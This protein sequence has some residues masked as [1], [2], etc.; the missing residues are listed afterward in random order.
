MPASFDGFS[1][2][3]SSLVPIR[4]AFYAIPTDLRLITRGQDTVIDALELARERFPEAGQFQVY[5]ESFYGS[6]QTDMQFW[7]SYPRK[8]VSYPDE[9]S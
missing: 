2:N 5:A 9:S 4:R 3:R 1:E 6:E 7:A 8:S